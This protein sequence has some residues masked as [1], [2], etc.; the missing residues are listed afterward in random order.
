MRVRLVR[1]FAVSPDRL[2]QSATDL[3]HLRRVCAGLVTFDDCVPREGRIA[4]GDR[5]DTVVRL[6]GRFPPQRYRMEV[7]ELDDAGMRFR[8]EESG[9]GVRRW[10][11]RLE[12]RPH[13]NGARM[14]ETIDIDAGP[15]T[16][17]LALWARILYTIRGRRR[18]RILAQGTA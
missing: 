3:G 2:W 1:D 15:A 7:A 12:V 14:E 9:A 13:P 18:A 16:P 10:T 8:S 6:F 5:F 17:L 11:H 4:E